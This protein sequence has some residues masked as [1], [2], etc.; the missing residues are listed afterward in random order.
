MINNFPTYNQYPNYP[1]GCES[2]ALYTLLKY[3]NVD[4]TPNDIVEKLRKGS[5]PHYENGVLYAADPEVEFVGDPR[6]Y[7]GYGVYQK[8]IIDVA[9]YYKPGIIDYTGNS[10]NSVLELVKKNIPVQVWGSINMQN[11]YVST[12][13]IN[14]D[15]GKRIYWI[16]NLHSVV[17]VGFNSNYIYVSDPY[18]GSIVKYNRYQFEK[19]Y[20]LFGKRAIYYNN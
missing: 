9:V 7:T 12:S 1:N 11:T 13:W 8:P 5:S 20:N 16:R 2:I 17:I 10:L 6:L 3:Y 15:T 19:M 14:K 18:V 4:V